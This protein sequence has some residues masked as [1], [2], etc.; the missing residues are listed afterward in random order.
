VIRLSEGH[1]VPSA[2]QLAK[3]KYCKWHDSYSH[4]T[5]E[6]NY[7]RRHRQSALND[8]QL[9]LDEGAEMKLDTNLFPVSMVNLEEKKILV[10]SDQTDTTWGKNVIV[11]D[12][13][14]H[15]MIVPHSP[16]VGTWKEN[17]ARKATQRVKLTSAMLIEKYL[18]QQQDGF[19]SCSARGRGHPATGPVNPVSH[20]RGQLQ[21]PGYAQP[22][23]GGHMREEMRAHAIA[24]PSGDVQQTSHTRKPIERGSKA[25]MMQGG[26]TTK[27]GVI[28]D[29]GK[30]VILIIVVL[31][32]LSSE[33]HMNGRCM[34]TVGPTDEVVTADESG[35]TK[36]K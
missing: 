10:H 27:S 17:V 8:G 9:T 7:F 14:R 35:S 24:R 28:D 25:I 32:K 23:G 4:T 21:H 31:C 26:E 6:C 34:A 22:R 29:G 3:R 15:Q 33:V 5:I 36:Q 30:D 16:K 13:L 11:S 1:V 2:E 19:T 18:R 12:E 20:G